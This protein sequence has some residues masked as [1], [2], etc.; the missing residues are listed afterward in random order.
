MTAT[1]S[2]E[3]RRAHDLTLSGTPDA[4]VKAGTIAKTALKTEPHNW[5]AWLILG[6]AHNFLRQWDD[7]ERAFNRTLAFGTEPMGVC[8]AWLGLTIIQEVRGDLAGAVEFAYRATKAMPKHAAPCLKYADMLRN[9]GR[10]DDA[11]AAYTRA[12]Q[13]DPNWLDIKYNRGFLRFRQGRWKEGWRAYG[14]RWE[15]QEFL[16][17]VTSRPDTKKP[18]WGGAPLKTQKLLVWAEQGLGDNIWA[19]R[20]LDVLLEKYPQATISVKTPN[21][22]YRHVQHN[23]GDRV[24]VTHYDHPVPEHD[25]HVPVMN[26]PYALETWDPRPEVRQRC[27]QPRSWEPKTVGIVWAGRPAY[28]YDASRSTHIR[29]WDALLSVPGYRFV[30]L[31]F[32]GA[33]QGSPYFADGRLLD[34][35]PEMTDFADTANLV[36]NLDLVV[37]VDTAVMH[38]AASLGVPTWWLLGPQADYRWQYPPNTTDTAWYSTA[39]L[40]RMPIPGIPW[41]TL[42]E[43]VAGA[44]HD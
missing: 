13:L 20:Y 18:L 33:D 23:Y 38:L 27:M 44:L 32:E 17:T 1:I 34:L 12:L 43:S 9:I 36:A 10:L 40:W 21:T 2:D 15:T 24:E 4:A 35:R 8:D 26:L 11:E 3:L 41:K 6:K 31:Q 42:L 22:L 37:G 19:M 30:S 29:D 28:I 25:V 5:L 39:R 16:N 14:M 7:A